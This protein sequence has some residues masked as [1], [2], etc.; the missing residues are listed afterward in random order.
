MSI[1]GVNDNRQ[2]N[3][4]MEVQHFVNIDACG[5]MWQDGVYLFA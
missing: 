1:L 4:G 5:I 2:R 3:S